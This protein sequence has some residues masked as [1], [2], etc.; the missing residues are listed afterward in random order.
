[1]VLPCKHLLQSCSVPT[2]FQ[3]MTFSSSVTYLILSDF[4]MH[5]NC[6]HPTSWFSDNPLNYLPL[7]F[8]TSA[9]VSVGFL[10]SPCS[11]SE[12]SMPETNSAFPSTVASPCSCWTESQSLKTHHPGLLH[13]LYSYICNGILAP[14][15]VTKTTCLPCSLGQDPSLIRDISNPKSGILHSA[16]SWSTCWFHS[17]LEIPVS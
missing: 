8:Q 3:H 9:I 2:N 15:L 17:E 1:M 7:C 5:L 6:C 4:S 12:L 11:Y 16:S 14:C 13:C 10:P